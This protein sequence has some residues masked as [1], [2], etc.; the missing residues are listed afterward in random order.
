MN[1]ICVTG[2][3]G[4]IG[5]RLLNLGAFPLLC[6]VRSREEVEQAITRCK[7]DVIIH[8]AAKSDPTF[9]ENN[10]REA[11]A[12][13]TFGTNI[14]C[15]IAEKVLGAGKVVLISSDQVFDGKKG[16]YKESV[17]PNPINNYGLTKFAAEGIANLYSDKIIRISS[18]FDSKSKDISGYLK[19]IKNDEYIEVPKH[20]FRS[21][22]HYDFIAEAIC[23]YAQRFE[24]MPNVL[25]LGG[26]YFMSFFSMVQ[27]IAQEYLLDERLVRPR[28]EALGFSN[29]PA[30]CGLDVSLARKLG[31][32]IYTSHQSIQRMKNEV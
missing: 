8:L 18:C 19:K 16:N 27:Q 20:I 1:K 17:E 14:V 3:K 11:I 21:Y 13:N 25:H 29:R 22:A 15:E 9:C 26:Y 24:E 4:N 12:V 7:P 23:Q 32:P 31:L 6:D 30:K 2:Y 10:Y 5:S 28:G